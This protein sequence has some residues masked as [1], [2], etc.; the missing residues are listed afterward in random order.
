[1]QN[2]KKKEMMSFRSKGE[3]L[4][5]LYLARTKKKKEE[6]KRIKLMLEF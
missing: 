2:K 5:S 6:E 3:F 1:M 4:Q